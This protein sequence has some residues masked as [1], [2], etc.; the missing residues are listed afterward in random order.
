MKSV[1]INDDEP[2]KVKMVIDY[3]KDEGINSIFGSNGLPPKPVEVFVEE[4]DYEK[5]L[6]I[7]KNTESLSTISLG[8]NDAALKIRKLVLL[9]SIV[10]ALIAA[11][12]SFFLK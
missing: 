11:L 7:I 3:L 8:N 2:S 4:Q 10:A 12:F 1:Y 6:S 5:A 9:V